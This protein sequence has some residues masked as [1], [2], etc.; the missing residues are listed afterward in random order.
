MNTYS[1]ASRKQLDTCHP[2]L[3][4]VF[5]AVL[6]IHDHTVIQGHR[7]LEEQEADFNAGKSKLHQGTHNKTPSEGVDVGPYIPG[8]GIPW[9]Q[10]GSPTYLKDTCA[11]YLFAG[12]V[13]ATADH[14]GIKIRWGGDWDRDGDITDQVF[15]DL[16]HFELLQEKP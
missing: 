5:E 6:E 11:F 9:P 10:K 14:L 15:D 16:T 4:Q 12:I 1:K 2:L 13:L 7:S 8:R 3:Q